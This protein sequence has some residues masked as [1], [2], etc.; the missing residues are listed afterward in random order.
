MS[1]GHPHDVDCDA[2]LAQVYEYLD[3]E[4]DHATL[5]SIRVHLDECGPCLRE[6]GLEQAV[7]ALVARCCGADHAP[8]GLRSRVIARI[9]IVR[10]EYRVQP[11]AE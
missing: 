4:I 3:G 6:Y 7:M 10:A 9:E 11:P 1:C 2:V 8:E 5:D